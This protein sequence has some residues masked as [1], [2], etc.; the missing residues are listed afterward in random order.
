VTK[1]PA[2]LP[3]LGRS[4]L[5]DEVAQELE[6]RILDGTFPAGERMPTES[7]LC[8]GF[9]VSRTVIRDALRLLEAGGLVETRR[10][11]GTIVKPTSPEAYASAAALALLRSDLTLG[12]VFEARAALEGQLAL[13]AAER[14]RPE[15]LERIRAALRCFEEAV[16]GRDDE[17]VVTTH[18][19]FHT[20][21]LRATD[22]PALEILLG[23]VQTL[24]LVTSVTAG[25]EASPDPAA[26]RLEV[27]RRLADAIAS[28]DPTAVAAASEAHWSTPIRGERYRRIRRKRVG[29]VFDSPRALLRESRLGGGT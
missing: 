23:P 8:A 9:G 28:R 6:R 21:L 14:H 26:W 2:A 13:V 7:E 18:V 5:R 15:H 24:M 20:E 29:T 27:H 17:A 11:A 3:R 1:A 10:G 19:A 4:V 16:T 22:L 12:E 25:D